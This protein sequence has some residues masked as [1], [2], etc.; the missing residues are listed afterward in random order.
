MSKGQQKEL[1]S[2]LHSNGEFEGFVHRQHRKKIKKINPK[3]LKINQL[4]E[5]ELLNEIKKFST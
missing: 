1:I 3:R 2:Y 4:R 5:Q